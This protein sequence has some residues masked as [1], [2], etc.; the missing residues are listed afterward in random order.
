MDQVNPWARL[1]LRARERREKQQTT[2]IS[3]ELLPNLRPKEATD[4]AVLLKRDA[5][6]TRMGEIKVSL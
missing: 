5:R 4:T 6:T 1:I 2:A 3:P